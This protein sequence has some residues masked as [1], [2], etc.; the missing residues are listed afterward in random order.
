MAKKTKKTMKKLYKKI[1]NNSDIIDS[2]YKKGYEQA[3]K[4]ILD[5]IEQLDKEEESK[6]NP[7]FVS[8]DFQIG[9]DGAYEHNED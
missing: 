6:E 5:K 8:D 4:D 1:R 3:L 2:A 9:P 7:P